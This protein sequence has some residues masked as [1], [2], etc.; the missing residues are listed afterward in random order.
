MSKRGNDFLKTW[1]ER[2]ITDDERNG[3]QMRAMT[4]ADNCIAEAAKVGISESDLEPSWGSIESIIFEAMR[5]DKKTI[6]ELWEAFARA[7]RID[8]L[9]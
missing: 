1:I 5:N 6:E 7:H 2:N 4:L 9:S 3:S 8:A